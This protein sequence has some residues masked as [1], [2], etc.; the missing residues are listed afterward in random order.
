MDIKKRLY[1]YG[2]S[3][4]Y[5]ERLGVGFSHWIPPTFLFGYDEHYRSLGKEMIVI[6][7]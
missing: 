2:G 3:H 6:E 5:H 7:I 1:R 4:S